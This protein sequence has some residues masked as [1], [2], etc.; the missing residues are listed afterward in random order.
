MA[1]FTGKKPLP[2]LVEKSGGKPQIKNG[3]DDHGFLLKAVY[4]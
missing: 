2:Q 1:H 4:S 3:A